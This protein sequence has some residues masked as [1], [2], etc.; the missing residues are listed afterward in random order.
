MT[1]VIIIGA[2]A[3]GQMTVGQ[4][5]EERSSFKLF[6]NHMTIE[7]VAPFFSYG[8][9]QGRAL[10][11]NLRSGFFDAFA[12]DT[13]G[14]YIFTYVWA[15]DAQGE[16]AYIEGIAQRFSAQG[17]QIIWVELT[18]SQQ[19]RLRRN[20]TDNRLHHKPAKRDID[21][22]ENNLLDSDQS[23]RLTSHPQEIADGDCLQIDTTK[24]TATQTADQIH[25]H[26]TARSKP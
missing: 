17:H 7:M 5:L 1:L 11:Q 3:V 18:A 26:I 6:H 9:A 12:Q 8:T 21:W 15:F 20:K 16:R 22:S 23:H 19:E 4:A 2:P 24:L 25:R 13:E 14:N 10:V